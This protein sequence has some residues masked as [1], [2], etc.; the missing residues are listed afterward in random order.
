MTRGHTA[1]VDGIEGRLELLPRESKRTLAFLR[2]AL[3]LLR[4]ESFTAEALSA[5][6]QYEAEHE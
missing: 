4:R 3:L 2:L 1:V 6:A 5:E